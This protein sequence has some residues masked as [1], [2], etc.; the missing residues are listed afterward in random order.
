MTHNEVAIRRNRI[1]CYIDEHPTVNLSMPQY[2]AKELGLEY[3]STKN[4]CD[5]LKS[6]YKML[7]A[8]FNHEGLI[9]SYRKKYERLEV[10]RKQAQDMQEAEDTT[11]KDKREAIQLEMNIINNQYH[12]ESDGLNPLIEELDERDSTDD[13]II[14]S[15][16]DSTVDDSTDNST[17]LEVEDDQLENKASS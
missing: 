6:K 5:F 9:N 3:K 1:S 2:I 8:Q 16:I 17:D 11:D 10:L 14:D 15:T 4:D 7:N 13:N 12:L